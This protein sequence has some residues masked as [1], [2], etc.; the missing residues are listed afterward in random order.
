MLYVLLIVAAVQVFFCTM[1]F[2]NV[3][4]IPDMVLD[5]VHGGLKPAAA[6]R[7]LSVVICAR[8]EAGNLSRYL[9]IVLDQDYFD[10]E[11][12]HAFEVIVVDDASTDGTASVLNGLAQKYPHLSVIRIEPDQ[13]RLYPG[14]KT[15]LSAGVDAAKADCIVCTDADCYPASSIWLQSMAVPFS[16]GFDIVAGYGGYESRPGWLNVFIR[17]ET[18][19]TFLL[20][21]SLL[22]EGD[23]YMAV[24][25]NLGFRKKIFYSAQAHPLWLRTPSGDDDLLIQLCATRF[26]MEVLTHPASFTLS[27]PKEHWRDYLLQKRRH[28]STGK[29]YAL[30]PRMMVGSYALANTLWWIMLPVCFFYSTEIHY[31]YFLLLLPALVLQQI[32]Q[33]GANYLEHSTTYFRWL[34][35]SFCWMLY[36]A[37]LAPYI[38][39]KTKQRWK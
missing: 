14:K 35:F 21:Y 36:N 5:V 8:N 17:Y 31:I 4:R 1:V 38:L 23:P 15:A 2:W 10:K 19:H 7:P 12:N 20:Y 6:L 24:G 25:R 30:A 18:L 16:A 39:W 28:V 32:L 9:P 13:E 27:Q 3:Y 37:V 11:G 26:N 29:L 22:K 34:L 33:D